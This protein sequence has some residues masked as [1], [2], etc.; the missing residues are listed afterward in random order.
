MP[1][2]LNRISIEIEHYNGATYM[3][4]MLSIK[5]D[6]TVEVVDTKGCNLADTDSD[7]IFE[8]ENDLHRIQAD[9]PIP[10]SVYLEIMDCYKEHENS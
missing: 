5:D 7:Y 1:K 4:L 10:E 8:S 9:E 3:A 6:G 2:E